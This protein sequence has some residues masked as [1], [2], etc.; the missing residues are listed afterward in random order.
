MFR[1]KSPTSTKWFISPKLELGESPIHGIGVFALEPIE[2][3]ELLESAPVVLCHEDTLESFMNLPSAVLFQGGLGTSSF[4]RHIFLDYIFKFGPG[5]LAFPLGWAGIYNHSP[6][7]NAFWKIISEDPRPPRGQP[8]PAGRFQSIPSGYNALLF[9]A[10]RNI[11]PGEEI[12]TLYHRRH[13]DLWFVDPDDD[14][15]GSDEP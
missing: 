13:Q 1:E 15:S 9:R 12:M 6:D 5:Q 8:H 11:G 14:P 7:P 10:K 2:K 4:T 3:Y